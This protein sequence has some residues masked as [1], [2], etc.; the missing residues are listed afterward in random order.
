MEVHVNFYDRG[1]HYEIKGTSVNSEYEIKG[2]HDKNKK[3]AIAHAQE[4]L[5]NHN[6]ESPNRPDYIFATYTF[7]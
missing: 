1:N 7:H 6:R 3:G 2:Y 5:D 4:A